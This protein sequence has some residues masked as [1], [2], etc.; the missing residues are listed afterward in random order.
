MP[1]RVRRL[2]M[3][4][5]SIKKAGTLIAIIGPSTN[6]IT[7]FSIIDTASGARSSTGTEQ[8]VTTQR[9]TGSQCNIGD[10]VKYVNLIIQTGAR[11]ETPEDDTSGF[12][13]WAVVKS[14]EATVAPVTTNLSILTLGALCTHAFRGDTLLTGA[15][16]VGGDQ[17]SVAN[18]QIKIPKIFCKM[19]IGSTLT[20]Y[21]HFRSTNMASV[22]T[23][24]NS[25]IMS[26]N[27][28]CYM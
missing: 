5:D 18:I 17:P 26:Y 12:L 8:I 19:Q 15:I 23:N 7:A 13:E 21:V 24:L 6:P 14:K 10:I 9:D 4:K 11:D 22:A 27:Y 25:C 20:L 2:T 16:P 28:K 1:R 3:G